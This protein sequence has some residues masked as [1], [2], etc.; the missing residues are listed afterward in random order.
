[1]AF[2]LLLARLLPEQSPKGHFAEDKP[3]EIVIRL[4]SSPRLLE[5]AIL[6]T[7]KISIIMAGLDSKREKER[8]KNEKILTHSPWDCRYALRVDRRLDALQ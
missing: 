5:D 2:K 4:S 8:E 7:Q 1:M 3:L 6:R